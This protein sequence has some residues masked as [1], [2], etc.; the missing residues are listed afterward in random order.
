MLISWF[1]G[2][3]LRRLLTHDQVQNASGACLRRCYSPNPSWL[4]SMPLAGCLVSPCS[5]H[6]GLSSAPLAV[7]AIPRFSRRLGCSLFLTLSQHV[8][9]AAPTC[10]SDRSFTDPPLKAVAEAPVQLGP[11]GFCSQS[12]Q[13]FSWA[14]PLLFTFVMSF[15]PPLPQGGQGGSGLR[16]RSLGSNAEQ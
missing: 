12:T 10:S 3:K 5:G 6:T 8:A 1:P 11:P 14:H 15:L 16:H 4:Q 2:F 9:R 13:Q 7:Q